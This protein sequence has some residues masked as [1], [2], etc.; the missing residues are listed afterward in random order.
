MSTGT[1]AIKPNTEMRVIAAGILSGVNI[2]VSGDPGEGKTA[3]L[4][5]ASA[6]SGYHTET[7]VTSTR[8]P[9]DFLG[10]PTA[11]EEEGVM[12]YLPLRWAVEL[13]K[14]R[15]SLAIFDEFSLS[16]DS[17]RATL[18]TF[19]ERRVGDVQLK[20]SVTCLAI[21]NPVEVSVGGV[22]LPAAVSNRFLHVNWNFDTDEWLANIMTNFKNQDPIS[23]EEIT[24]LNPSSSDRIRGRAYVHGFI[25]KSRH[26]L[27]PGA[28]RDPEAAS[29]P[30]PSPRSWTY[31]ANILGCLRPDDEDAIYAAAS[32]AVGKAAASDFST[33]MRE[34]DLIDP[35][36][37][38]RNPKSVDFDG[39]RIDII[40][41]L[42]SSVE[43]NVFA[44]SDQWWKPAMNLLV[45][46]AKSKRRDI[47][48]PAAEKILN[49]QPKGQ[50]IPEAFRTSLL[51]LLDRAGLVSDDAD[52]KE[53]VM[54]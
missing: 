43:A 10:Y 54:A 6:L 21:M 52:E 3:K 5:S 16:V 32:G 12:E 31:L 53:E 40:L 2:L 51:P 17:F 9:Q 44:D 1:T 35:V 30:W 23:L 19:A 34:L 49:N 29:K 27:K 33:Y 50:K 28:P 22:D 18:Q 13:N 37:A 39:K 24:G 14:H 11:N 45:A 38:M 4:E 25:Q 46:C 42:L 26:L 20:D 8:E 48:V 15:K 7:L 41:T 36:E 47:A